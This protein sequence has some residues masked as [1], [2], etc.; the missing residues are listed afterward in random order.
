MIPA[1]FI[2]LIGL[3]RVVWAAGCT[4]IFGECQGALW[5]TDANASILELS[6]IGRAGTTSRSSAQTDELPMLQSL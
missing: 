3:A 1:G 2:D 4:A 5:P 6:R